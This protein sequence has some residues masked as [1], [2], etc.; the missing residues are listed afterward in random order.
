MSSFDTPPETASHD[1]MCALMERATSV[2][3]R[4][5]KTQFVDVAMFCGDKVLV[6]HS[7]CFWRQSLQSKPTIRKVYPLGVTTE[8]NNELGILVHEFGLRAACVVEIHEPLTSAEYANFPFVSEITGDRIAKST[9]EEMLAKMAG[10]TT[11]PSVRVTQL[12]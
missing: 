9:I 10:T 12:A 4:S 1:D 6:R 5:L 7:V 3:F 11:T 8:C 2:D